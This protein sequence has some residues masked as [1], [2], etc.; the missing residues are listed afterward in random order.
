MKWTILFIVHVIVLLAAIGLLWYA[1][2][3]PVNHRYRTVVL[4]R[5]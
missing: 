3:M 2:T 4:E 5:K 1:I